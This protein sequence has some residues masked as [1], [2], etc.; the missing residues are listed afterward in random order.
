MSIDKGVKE[1]G[2][3]SKRAEVIVTGKKTEAGGLALKSGETEHDNG[4]GGN[5]IKWY[6]SSF[7]HDV[8]GFFGDNKQGRH[9]GD[10]SKG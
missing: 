8:G 6:G 4:T 9:G 5:R 10:G 7:N 2:K 3:I 1:R